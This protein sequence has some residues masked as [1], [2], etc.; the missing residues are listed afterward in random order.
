MHTSS[1]YYFDI[2]VILYLITPTGAW[3][4]TISF[5]LFPNNAAPKGDSFDILFWDKST[6]VEPTIVYSISSSNSI[7]KTLTMFPTWT[8]SKSTS[9]SSIILTIF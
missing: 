5:F 9:D 7:S 1:L 2:F 3:T 8:V 4:S 6:S